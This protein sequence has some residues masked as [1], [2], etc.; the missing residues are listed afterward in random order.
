MSQHRQQSFPSPRG[1]QTP[2]EATDCE[3]QANRLPGAKIAHDCSRGW[4]YMTLG[5][6]G[7]ASCSL[8]LPCLQTGN[9][10]PWLQLWAVKAS[11]PE[12]RIRDPH[13]ASWAWVLLRALSLMSV[14]GINNSSDQLLTCNICL[15]VPLMLHLRP[16]IRTYG[17]HGTP[18]GRSAERTLN[19]P[20]V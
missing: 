14:H 2:A 8:P 5:T 16:L 15:S 1:W 10:R 17:Q 11:H 18:S 7:H 19:D 9:Q 13:P 20:D 12:R 4:V 3:S 6:G